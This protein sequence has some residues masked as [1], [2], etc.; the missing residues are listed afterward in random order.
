M[1]KFNVF[2]DR[3]FGNYLVREEKSKRVKWRKFKV[4]GDTIKKTNKHIMKVLEKKEGSKVYSR[5]MGDF[6][7]L[8]SGEENEHSHPRSWILPKR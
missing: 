3:P 5:N 8:E 4:L 7:L 2:R 1:K 6:K